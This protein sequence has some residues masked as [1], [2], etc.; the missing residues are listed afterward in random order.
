MGSS[1]AYD[2]M[3]QFWDKNRKLNRPLSPHLS[4]YKP[5]LTS[6]LSL[7][8][9]ATGI[10][11]AVTIPAVATALMVLPGDLASYLEMIKSLD[12]G[13]AIIT[14][15]KYILGFPVIYHYINGIR[16]LA[17]DWALGFSMKDT[18]RTGWFVFTLSFL[19]TAAAVHFL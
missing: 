16:H 7:C 8:H 4:I 5:Q 3:R 15:A 17:W 1:T 13:S 14:A 10:M 18:Y 11:M 19:V 12:M 9:R 2:E 6:M